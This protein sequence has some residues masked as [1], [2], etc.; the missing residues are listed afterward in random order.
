MDA[1]PFHSSARLS[2]VF[3]LKVPLVVDIGVGDN[4]AEITKMT[5][6]G[7]LQ[8][9]ADIG[10]LRRQAE[11]EEVVGSPEERLDGVA[12]NRRESDEQSRA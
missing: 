11:L 12:P 7:T 10:E 5:D 3:E 8:T 4:W 6:P 2:S 1:V 9:S